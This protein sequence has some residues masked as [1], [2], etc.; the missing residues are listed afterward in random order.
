MGVRFRRG[1]VFK[2][3]RLVHHSTLGA[4]VTQK[5]VRSQ[6]LPQ[7]MAYWGCR[8]FES[9]T[10]HHLTIVCCEI[11]FAALVASIDTR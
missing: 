2:A 1:L 6:D 11:S 10:P 3:D 9:P 5:K 4:R 7:H 8:V